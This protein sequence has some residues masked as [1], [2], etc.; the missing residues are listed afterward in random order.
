[1]K[2]SDRIKRRWAKMPRDF[3]IKGQITK[4]NQMGKGCIKCAKKPVDKVCEI[5][6]GNSPEVTF[7]PICKECHANT[8]FEEI[9]DFFHKLGI[10][11]P[12]GKKK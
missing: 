11:L 9:A 1:V 12:E 4:M 5:H 10:G 6:W 7:Y 8:S 2:D 3:Y